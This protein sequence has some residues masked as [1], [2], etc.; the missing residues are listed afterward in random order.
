MMQ[1]FIMVAVV[2]LAAFVLVYLQVNAMK[3]K[4]TTK[5]LSAILVVGPVILVMVIVG[6]K[7]MVAL[8]IEGLEDGQ[9][10][11]TQIIAAT[12]GVRDQKPVAHVRRIVPVL[13][14][15]FAQITLLKGV[16]PAIPRAATVISAPKHRL[17]TV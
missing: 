12:V 5:K 9:L 3:T 1:Y 7:M 17:Q 10:L 13:A 4:K 16:K 6:M 11:V 15:R 2:E 14:S 8:T